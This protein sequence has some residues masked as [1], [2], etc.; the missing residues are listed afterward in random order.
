MAFRKKTSHD[1]GCYQLLERRM[2]ISSTF[3]TFG[4]N[5]ET[6]GGLQILIMRLGMN[7]IHYLVKSLRLI[8]QQGLHPLIIE[9]D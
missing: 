2:R 9:G 6:I 3:V 1:G 7:I 8:E 4:S 5:L